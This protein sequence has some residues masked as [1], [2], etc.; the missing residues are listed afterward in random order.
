MIKKTKKTNS[1]NKGAVKYA[2]L[3]LTKTTGKIV[4][5]NILAKK[6]FKKNIKEIRKYKVELTS[7]AQDIKIDSK[8]SQNETN[9]RNLYST[10]DRYKLLYEFSNDAITT[11]E[12][13]DWRFASGNPAT[14]KLFNLKDETQFASLAPSDLSP[15]KQPDGQL[16][17][18]KAKKMIELA[19]KN[20]ENTFEWTHKKLHGEPFSAIVNLIRINENSKQILQAVIHDISNRKT[21]EDELQKKI[22][23]ADKLNKL[24]IGRELK[25][26]ELKKEIQTL[27]NNRTNIDS[28]KDDQLEEGIEIEEDIIQVLEHDYEAMIHDSELDITKKSQIIE[29]LQTLLSDSRRHEQALKDLE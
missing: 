29:K 10:N 9:Q 2:L 5:A 1:K 12:P 19:L 8:I 11:L 16:S 26:I 27:R 18:E 22:E 6:L 14:I 24:M 7:S 25:M 4:D 17:N 23:E 3:T 13:P 15:E 20:G 28:N 21:V